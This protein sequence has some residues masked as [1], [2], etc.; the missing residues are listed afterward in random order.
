MR[1]GTFCLYDPPA[2]LRSGA[3]LE[4]ENVLRSRPFVAIFVGE[5]LKE[6]CRMYGYLMLL[7]VNLEVEL[8]VC[9]Q[10]LSLALSLKKARPRF[11]GDPD[12]AKFED[13][14]KMFAAQLDRRDAGSRQLVDDLHRARKLRNRLAHGFL[15]VGPSKDYLTPGGREKALHNLKQAEKVIFPLI[16]IVNL[17]G[18]AYASEVGVTTE[19]IKKLSERHKQEQKQ[20]ES[21]LKELLK[22][23]GEGAKT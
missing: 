8:R 10:Y 21:D 11:S 3:A 4:K 15:D 18:R 9:L 17:V 5:G 16:M 22:D 2:E 1:S 20:I 7:G 23:S 12:T 6:I 13:L 19:Y 14:I